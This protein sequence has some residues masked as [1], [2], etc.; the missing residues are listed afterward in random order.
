MPNI[1]SFAHIIT[2]PII[3]PNLFFIKCHKNK[4]TAVIYT[5]SIEKLIQELYN[6]IIITT[7]SEIYEKI[8]MLSYFRDYGC[9]FIYR[10]SVRLI[11]GR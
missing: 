4:I 6:L 11:G 2:V 9:R 8:S 5:G 7:R 3:Y 10:A 1:Y